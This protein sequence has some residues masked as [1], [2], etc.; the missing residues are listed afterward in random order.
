[1]TTL[2]G[3]K[4]RYRTRSSLSRSLRKH[5]QRSLRRKYA[6]SRKLSTRCKGKGPKTCKKTPG[7]KYVRGKAGKYC[8]RS[9][10]P[11]RYTKKSNRK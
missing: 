11:R 5:K 7:C 2:N 8:R 6:K 4:R 3:G 10:A 9:K 1:M